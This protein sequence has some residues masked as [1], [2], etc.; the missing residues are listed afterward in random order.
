MKPSQ[1]IETVER[2]TLGILLAFLALNAF[3]GGYYGM[4]GAKNIPL[5]WLHGSPFQNYF[6]PSLFLFSVIGGS[7]L[8]AA[9]AVFSQSPIARVAALFC[10]TIVLFWIAVQVIIIGYVSWMQPVTAAAAIAI[11]ILARLLLNYSHL[12]K[13]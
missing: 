3:G 11:L 1:L 9:I 12:N 4:T 8:V 7:A 2:Y 5:E 6:I 13:R 10:G